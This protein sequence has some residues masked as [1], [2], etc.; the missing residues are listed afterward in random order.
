MEA[1][2]GE[3]PEWRGASEWRGAIGASVRQA[4]SPTQ[5]G[6]Y[7]DEQRPGC[8]IAEIITC[9][10]SD[11]CYRLPPHKAQRT[12]HATSFSSTTLPGLQL[13]TYFIIVRTFN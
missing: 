5:K 3:P 9:V 11:I 2:T 10:A 4:P 8:K 7:S 12:I 13:L 1:C 6:W